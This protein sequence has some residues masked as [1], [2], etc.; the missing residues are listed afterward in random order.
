[1]PH[2]STEA[3]PAQQTEITGERT[4]DVPSHLSKLV[5]QVLEKPELHDDNRGMLKDWL[6]FCDH[7]SLDFEP[8]TKGEATIRIKDG[9][10]GDPRLFL[11]EDLTFAEAI[12]A[13]NVVLEHTY[14]NRPDRLAERQ[15]YL[16]GQARNFDIAARYFK[17]RAAAFEGEAWVDGVKDYAS[18][19]TKIAEA[20]SPH[21]PPEDEQTPLPPEEI[22]QAERW[23]LGNEVYQ[24]ATAPDKHQGLDEA[25][26]KYFSHVFQK[27]SDDN[28]SAIERFA[29][30]KITSAMRPGMLGV[31][32]VKVAAYDR[33]LD[34]LA[35][36]IQLPRSYESLFQF[37]KDTSPLLADLLGIVSRRQKLEDLRAQNATP[38]I[39]S[40]L[41]LEIADDVQRAVVRYTYDEN[42]ISP[43]KMIETRQMNCL[44]SSM[45]ASSLLHAAGIEPLGVSLAD[46]SVL[47]I[48]TADGKFYWRDYTGPGSLFD[49]CEITPDMFDGDRREQ[50]DYF[51]ALKNSRDSPKQL[52]LGRWNTHGNALMERGMGRSITVGESMRMT[53]ADAHDIL[54]NAYS[55][56]GQPDDAIACYEEAILLN[57]RLAMAH[58]NLGATY[59]EQGQPDDAIACYE[60]AIRL[61][62]GLAMAHRNI[63]DTYSERQQLDSAI[64][65]YM[66]AI[67]LNPNI[68]KVHNNLGAAY[69]EQRRVNK[70]ISCY[71]EAIRLNP[72]L[73]MAHDN[74]DHARKK[75]AQLNNPFV[76]A[77][78]RL[79]DLI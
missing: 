61:N 50:A 16:F 14:A 39:I 5:I 11:P 68:A 27:F 78:R 18:Q 47:I 10:N 15:E 67:R 30:K 23:L 17:E 38:E 51:S 73:A 60:E 13:A 24:R 2:S 65:C 42:A 21:R 20:L 55:E 25:H 71:E 9:E 44:G 59:S 49:N 52:V 63:G 62:P 53:Y 31:N 64:K 28:P 4:S 1:M 22:E 37:S 58:N 40:R 12:N 54:G 57:P 26:S 45:L 7:L 48:P 76:R 35:T 70:A 74:L 56:Q 77:T 19:F 75:Q 46:H 34:E 32:P 72:E 33:G 29:A 36:G 8:R 6:G 43:S 69:E 41:E 3:L 66:E 79:F